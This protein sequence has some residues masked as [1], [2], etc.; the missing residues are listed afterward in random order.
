MTLT[1]ASPPNGSW[2]ADGEGAAGLEGGVLAGHEGG[3]ARVLGRDAVAG[4]QGVGGSIG[5]EAGFVKKVQL[6]RG[7][8]AHAGQ[9]PCEP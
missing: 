1:F 5:G 3:M 7:S 6:T 4:A 8:T 2:T 9:V